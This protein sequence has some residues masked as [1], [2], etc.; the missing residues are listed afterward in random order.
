MSKLRLFILAA[1]LAAQ[2][3]FGFAVA[4]PSPWATEAAVEILKRGGNATDAM[5][6]ASFAL[7]VAQPYAMGI[8][9][10]GFFLVTTNGKTDFWDHRESGPASAHEKMFLGPNGKPLEHYPDRV[11]GPNP[12]GVPGTPAGLFE[13]H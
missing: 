6:A 5:V 4:T 1:L 9:G 7:N 12:V 11:T 13:A 8:G 10:G 3:A 2:N